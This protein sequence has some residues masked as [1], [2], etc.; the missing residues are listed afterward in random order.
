MP[1]QPATLPEKDQLPP[2]QRMVSV[3][4]P[5]FLTAGVATIIF[6]TL[7]DPVQLSL[8]AGGPEVPPAAF[9]AGVIPSTYVPFRNGQILAVAA[10]GLGSAQ[11]LPV[12][13]NRLAV[14][15]AQH[16]NQLNG[17]PRYSQ[18]RRNR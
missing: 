15:T 7:F 8:L 3:L 14:K 1:T 16:K 4:W 17:Y 10:A 13:F 5:S 9:S 12:D 11:V 18:R 2:V 6:F